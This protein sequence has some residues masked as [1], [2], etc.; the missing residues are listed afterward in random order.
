MSR[1]NW[2]LVARIE[3]PCYETRVA[4]LQK[5]AA[6]DRFRL[7]GEIALLIASHDTALLNAHDVPLLECVSER[8][9]TRLES[10]SCAPRDS[11]AVS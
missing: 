8:G 10:A 11:A 2:G 7:P 4:I 3:K 1:F 5:R 6:T 9:T